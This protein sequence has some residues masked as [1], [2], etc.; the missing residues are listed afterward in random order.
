MALANNITQWVVDQFALPLTSLRTY[1][2]QRVNPILPAS[3][4]EII[5]G[6]LA[7]APGGLLALNLTPTLTLTPRRPDTAQR[8][9]SN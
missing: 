4:S 6:E 7:G 8:D 3:H 2:R 1:Y 9:I 5:N